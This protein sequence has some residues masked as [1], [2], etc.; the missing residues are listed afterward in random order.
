MFHTLGGAK[1]F[2]SFDNLSFG[3]D[4]KYIISLLRAH[5]I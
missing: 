4:N 5:N 2:L 3:D 1:A